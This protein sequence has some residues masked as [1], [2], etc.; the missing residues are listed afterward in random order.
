MKAARKTPVMADVAR[1]AGVSPI[2]V[3]RVVNGNP[4]VKPETRAR[5]VAAIEQLGYRTN[6]AARTLA[7]GRSRILGVASIATTFY[8]PSRTLFGIA[9]AARARDHMV[10]FVTVPEPTVRDLRASFE[11]LSEAHAEGVI[12]IAPL[13]ESVRA[14]HRIQP[15]TPLVVTSAT[16]DA[17]ASVG[18]DQAAGAAMAVTHLLELGHR[19][20][21]HVRGPEGWIDSEARIHGWRSA[22]RAAKRP[23]PDPLT[24]DWSPRSGYELGRR[25]AEDPDVTAVFVANDQMALGLLLALREANRRVPHDVSVVGFDDT[26]ESAFYDPPLTTV[27]QDLAEVG[28]RSVDLLLDLMDGGDQQPVTIEPQLVVRMSSGRASTS[29]DAGAAEPIAWGTPRPST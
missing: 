24:G 3:S 8:G 15:S 27:R 29:S 22:L 11:Q 10:N 2:T 26:P 18:I 19:T 23:A 14:L 12:V 16:P 4:L 5:V 28:R 9:A 25:L 21:H 13:H 1:L 6:M 7:G 17:P 20:V